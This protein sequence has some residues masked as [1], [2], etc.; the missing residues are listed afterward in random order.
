MRPT[1]AKVPAL[2]AKLESAQ[3]ARTGPTEDELAVAKK[4]M[5]NTF[6]EVKTPATG[7]DLN[8]LTFRGSPDDVVNGPPRTRRSPPR[9]DRDTFGKYWSKENSIS[10]SW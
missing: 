5:A 4:Q 10:S 9:A 6:A 2:L 3:F 8:R 7:P 1:S